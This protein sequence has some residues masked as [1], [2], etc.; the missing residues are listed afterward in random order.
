MNNP[1]AF[2]YDLTSPQGMAKAIV[3]YIERNPVTATAVLTPFV[4]F[5]P[6]EVLGSS[7]VKTVQEMVEAF[8]QHSGETIAAQRVSAVEIIK[9]G[10]ENGAAKV[11][12]VMNQ[13]AGIDFGSDFD[14]FP[15]K[16][17]LNDRDE[18]IVEVEY[19]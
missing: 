8:W 11:Y 7:F 13:K 14:G 19:Q 6:D 3:D 9:A 16:C 5:L 17:S 15:F 1:N 10:K 18:M 4:E 2:Y 12:V